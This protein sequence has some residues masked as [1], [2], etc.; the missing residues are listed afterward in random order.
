MQQPET[1]E[2]TPQRPRDTNGQAAGGAEGLIYKG[3]V[4]GE[5]SN[6]GAGFLGC[7]SIGSSWLARVRGDRRDVVVRWQR[8]AK[9]NEVELVAAVKGASARE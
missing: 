9:K 3:T 6:C 1:T 8:A 5:P 4:N 7:K 2:H